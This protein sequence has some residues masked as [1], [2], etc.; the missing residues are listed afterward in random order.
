MGSSPTAS[1]S[2][3][4]RYANGRAARLKP[5]RLWVRLPP[6]VLGHGCK[7]SR[8]GRQSADHSGL[9]REMLWVRIPPELSDH[10]LV[11]QPGVLASPVT[12]RSWVQIPSGTLVGGTARY[13]NWQSG[14][15]QTRG[16]VG[17]TPTRATRGWFARVVLLTAA[18]KAVAIKREAE[19]E[20]STP[21]PPTAVL[22]EGPFV[23]RQGHQPLKLKRR[24]RFPHGPLDDSPSGGTGRRAGLRRTCPRGVGVRIS[25]WRLESLSRRAG[26]RPA[27]I[28]PACPDR[29]RGLGLAGGPVLGRV[30]YARRRRFDSPTRN[31]R[32]ST[33]R[34]AN[35]HRGQVESLVPVGSNPTR[36]TDR[37][38]SRRLAAKTPVLHTG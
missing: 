27:L 33:A 17:S 23:Y 21:S 1:A 12:R 7:C 14:E 2:R 26:A 20:G 3:V 38:S 37:N 36:A 31:C 4:P 10:V 8:L 28:R 32:C 34:Y 25:P 15:A 11:E 6:W 24:V 9:E 30:S 18:C 19:G 16:S 29:Y 35:W 13:A 22:D 5:G